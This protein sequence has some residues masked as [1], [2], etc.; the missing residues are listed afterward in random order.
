MDTNLSMTDFI[1]KSVDE[2]DEKIIFLG[3]R[4]QAKRI[5]DDVDALSASLVRLGVKKGDVAVIALPNI[6]QAFVALYALN[7]IGVI[8]DL[9]HPKCGEK[10]LEKTV[11]ETGASFVFLYEKSY[12][13][14]EKVLKESKS[15]AVICRVSDYKK[16]FFGKRNVRKNEN[17]SAIEY[18]SLIR[19]KGNVVSNASGEDIAVYLHS[20]G[21]T[22]ESKTVI[23]TN[24][25][26]N[27]A[28]Q[29][30]FGA[31][32]PY[33]GIRKEYAM[34]MALPMFHGFGLVVCVHLMMFCGKSVLLPRFR[35][36]EALRLMK[37]YPVAYLSLVPNMLRRLTDKKSF[38][39]KRLLPLKYVFVGGDRLNE[40]L[41]AKTEALLLKSGS[42]CRVAEGYGLSEAA[43]V[44]TI[45]TDG[46]KG[47]VGKPLPGVEIKITDKDGNPVK[48]GET[49]NISV[50]S[51]SIAEGY[52]E[53][54]MPTKTDE[55]KIWVETGDVGYMD[56]DGYLYYVGRIKRMIKIGGVGIYPQQV[57]DVAERTKSVEKACA[58]RVMR[59]GKPAIKLLVVA[60]NPSESLKKKIC[61]AV[62]KEI[63]PYAT[64]REIEFVKTIKTTGIGKTDY[65]YYEE[66]NN[67][68]EV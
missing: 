22:E 2:A 5:F 46:R 56:E 44:V 62:E 41:C 13:K 66:I 55:G 65:R 34:L 37:T 42:K 52:K 30:V 48:T 25:A 58:V 68:S 33:V 53:G 7:Q 67:S 29:N 17:D 24:R 51:P 38:S 49:G 28:A 50:S 21:T 31:V 3:E 32:D 12:K 15:A 43:G 8:A 9:I 39:G 60:K 6:P 57:E 54:V 20:G 14:Y 59:K 4:I 11:R 35:A 16:S 1:R 19:K 63:M 36:G 27:E 64:P 45:N 47:S 23:L 18:A 40:T 10:G 61:A 26:L